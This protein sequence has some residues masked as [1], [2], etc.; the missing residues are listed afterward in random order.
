MVST[1][2]FPFDR[3]DVMSEAAFLGDVS[4]LRTLIRD[5]WKSKPSC[6]FRLL[7]LHFAIWGGSLDAVKVLLLE[8]KQKLKNRSLV[9]ISYD[10][11]APL[12]A[13]ADGEELDGRKSRNI[14]R[15]KLREAVCKGFID[16]AWD[17]NICR[18]LLIRGR[19]DET[20]VF[21]SLPKDVC[22]LIV[23][24]YCFDRVLIFEDESANDNDDDDDDDENELE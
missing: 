10:R 7:P 21:A 17:W 2:F 18:L 11:N 13:L 12:T 1:C 22:K 14:D 16:V 20:S 15:Q 6:C 19:P 8:G 24:K 5:G 9:R 3:W 4:R 23:A